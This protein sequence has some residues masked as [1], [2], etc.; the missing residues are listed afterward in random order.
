MI[1]GGAGNPKGY[2]ATINSYQYGDARAISRIARLANDHHLAAEYTK[3]AESLK[4][5]VEE[6]LWDLSANFFK[7]LPRDLKRNTSSLVDVRELHGYTPWYFNLPSVNK[8]IAWEQ[9]VDEKGFKAKYGLTTAEQRHRKFQLSYKD[10]ECQ[11]NGPV[12]PYATSVTITAMANLLNNYEQGYVTK[13]DFFDALKTYAESQHR[14]LDNSTNIVPWID[15]NLH[16][17]TG[18][19]IARTRLKQ[20]FNGTWSDD[21]GGKERGKDYNHSTFVDL[22]IS[23]LIGLR[24]KAHDVVVIYPLIP[25]GVWDYFALHNV[26]YHGR[27]LSIIWDATGE[28]F[29]KGKG[30][31]VFVNGKLK[32]RTK[33]L[34]KIRFNL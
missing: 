17:Y 7:V 14:T 2:R 31:A 26:E 29:N 3:K 20:W 19:W 9:V 13:R 24:P 25:E 23:G 34:Q 11:W 1:V 28:K 21:K 4:R 18:D 6:V 32:A 12:W 30:L 16:P 15:E 8:S 33:T 10:H 22:I 5:N 27:L